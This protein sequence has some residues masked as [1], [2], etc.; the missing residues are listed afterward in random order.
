M[1]LRKTFIGRKYIMKKVLALTLALIMALSVAVT[2]FAATDNCT[3]TCPYC[4]KSF[5]KERIML[6][7][8]PTAA[9]AIRTAAAPLSLSFRLSMTSTLRSAPSKA[10]RSSPPRRR[11][12]SSLRTLTGKKSAARLSSFSRRS[13]SRI[14]PKSSLTSSR[15]SPSRISSTRSPVLLN[16]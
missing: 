13:P 2:A 3:N 14:L 12:S 9:K 5:D 8:A 16:N 7:I 15:R 1:L 6:S 11:S 4:Q 10:R